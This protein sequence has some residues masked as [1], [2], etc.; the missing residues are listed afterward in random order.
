MLQESQASNLAKYFPGRQVYLRSALRRFVVA[1]SIVG[2]FVA[3]LS[4]ATIRPLGP[5]EMSLHHLSSVNSKAASKA[6]RRSYTT[7]PHRLLSGIGSWY[8]DLF[9]GRETASGEIFDKDALTACHP[10]LPFGTL[11]RVVNLRN[12]RSVIVRINDRGIR[13]NRIIDLSSAAAERIGLIET[14]IAPVKLEIVPR[15]RS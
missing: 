10:T 5:K 8:G 7:T 13:P 12:R 14:G 2:S 3:V 1:S 6:H 9:D 15:D 11:V 4:V